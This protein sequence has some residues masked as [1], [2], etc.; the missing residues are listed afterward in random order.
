MNFIETC[1][2]LIS[3]DSSPTG[4]T[5]EL[6]DFLAS[7]ARDSGLIVDVLHE[8]QN[9][10]TQANIIVRTEQFNPGDREFLLQTHLDTVD[11]GNYSLWKK[12]DFNPFDAVIED[13]K[14]YG[15][16]VVEVKFDFLCKFNILIRLKD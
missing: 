12:N 8:M 3:L 5:V 6:V 7:R 13:S 10:V 15:L 11:P 4:S 9:G 14:I 1:R 2:K 16:G